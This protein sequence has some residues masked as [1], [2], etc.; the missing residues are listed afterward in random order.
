MSNQVNFKIFAGNIEEK[1][2]HILGGVCEIYREV[3]EIFLIART[4]INVCMY[5]CVYIHIYVAVYM[6][7]Q[8]FFHLTS[9]LS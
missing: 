2:S 6:Y 7:I 1:L 3:L 9:L 8:Q 4:T 5:T